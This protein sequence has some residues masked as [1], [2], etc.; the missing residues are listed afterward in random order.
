MASCQDKQTSLTD[1]V[2]LTLSPQTVR[3]ADPDFAEKYDLQYGSSDNSKDGGNYLDFYWPSGEGGVV[4][5]TIPVQLTFTVTGP[6][7]IEKDVEFRVVQ[8]NK[9]FSNDPGYYWSGWPGAT[10]QEFANDGVFTIE[11]G[12]RETV[13]DITLLLD[14]SRLDHIFDGKPP[15]PLG[16]TGYLTVFEVLPASLDDETV[17]LRVGKRD[18]SINVRKGF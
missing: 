18:F 9:S 16:P 5:Q 12:K 17:T 4:P 6:P 11:K 13:A 14:M 2:T 8:S 3:F 10:Y 7:N 15:V 1:R